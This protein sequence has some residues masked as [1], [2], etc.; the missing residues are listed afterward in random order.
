ML[1]LIKILLQLK[2]SYK[3]SWLDLIPRGRYGGVFV[4]ADCFIFLLLLRVSEI[5]E[6]QSLITGLVITSLFAVILGYFILSASDELDKKKQELK[7]L[8][9]EQRKLNI[10][11]AEREAYVTR[12]ENELASLRSRGRRTSDN[13]ESLLEENRQLKKKHDSVKKEYKKAT[14]ELEDLKEQ[15]IILQEPDADTTAL[16][17]ENKQLKENIA[18]LN[19][20]LTKKHFADVRPS[21]SEYIPYADGDNIED[22]K[23]SY[24]ALAKANHPDKDGKEERMKRLNQAWEEA[25][26]WFQE[27]KR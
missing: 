5:I 12:V 3:P 8:K 22:V 24:R 14:K 15:K 19:N 23:I 18:N 10:N 17:L 1:S 16:L 7:Q 20:E 25:Q 4:F 13:F 9:S 26:K 21:W 11:N 27:R 2:N 6:E